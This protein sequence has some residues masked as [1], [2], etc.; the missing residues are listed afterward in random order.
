MKSSGRAAGRTL[1]FE[2]KGGINVDSAG[3][4]HLEVAGAEKLKGSSEVFSEFFFDM[5]SLIFN[6]LVPLLP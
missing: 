3:G 1:L 5:E 4:S 2:R 6:T